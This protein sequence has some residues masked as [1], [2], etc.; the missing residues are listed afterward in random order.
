MAT[1]LLKRFL[2]AIKWSIPVLLLFLSS[3]V[4][5]Q[6]VMIPSIP[7]GWP[8]HT[9]NA[10][11]SKRDTLIKHLKEYDQRVNDFNS[12]C[13]GTIP[14]E[15]K[16]LISYCQKESAALD[17]QSDELDKERDRFL[18]IFHDN[19]R[20]YAA[21]LASKAFQEK[22]EELINSKISEA[23]RQDSIRY[24][25]QLQQLMNDVSKIMVPSPGGSRKIHEGIILGLFN[26]D[27]KNAITDTAKQVISPFTNKQYAP[28][29]YFAT[30]DKLSAKELLRGVVDNGYLG[31]YTL[32]TAHGQQLVNKLQ[33]TQFDRLIAHSNGATVSEALIRNGVIKVEELNIIGGDR[34]LINNFG[35]NELITS[36]RV[37]RVVVWINPGDIIPYGSSAGL[38]SNPAAAVQTA[39]TALDYFSEKISGQSKGGDAK[40]EYRFLKGD[41]Y[42]GQQPG[43]GK[44]IFAA[45]GLEVYTE[46]MKNY[47]KSH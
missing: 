9:Q 41:Q 34:S 22:E 29:E 23:I 28:G 16:T 25:S 17:I 47:F 18:A 2:V 20:I 15:N 39:R 26:T 35:L 40:V 46:N 13:A 24:S 6:Q 38:F 30:S 45:H 37:K 19:E 42:K 32:N 44:D 11:N 7:A 21:Y 36:G 3:F 1:F 27:E 33:G 4:T 8:L 14:P 43:S 5:A 10:M 12:R 31:E